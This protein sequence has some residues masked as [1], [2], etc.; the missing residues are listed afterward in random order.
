MFRVVEEIEPDQLLTHLNLRMMG[1]KRAG[2]TEY[3]AVDAEERRICPV[4]LRQDRP[5]EE[6]KLPPDWEQIEAEFFGTASRISS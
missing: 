6:R 3:W 1:F 4:S 2:V 5:P